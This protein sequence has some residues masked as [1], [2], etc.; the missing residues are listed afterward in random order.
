MG[1]TLEFSIT[2]YLMQKI[3]VTFYLT[4]LELLVFC[5]HLLGF[6]AGTKTYKPV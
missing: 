5:S 4:S 6:K 3:V 2:D 1:T